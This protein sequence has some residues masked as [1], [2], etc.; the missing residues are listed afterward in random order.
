LTAVKFS[1]KVFKNGETEIDV[2]EDEKVEIEA[3][4]RIEVAK[5]DKQ[6]DQS[7][8]ILNFP[9]FLEVELFTNAIV[10]L[11]DVR[12]ESGGS[13]HVT[14]SL[15]QGHMFVGLTDDTNSRVTV[16][17]PD[18]VINTL[19][20][21]TEFNI[22]KAKDSLTCAQVEKGS[23]EITAE[24][25][26]EI[27]RAG[28]ASFIFKDEPPSSIICAP[29]EIFKAWK[30]QYRLKAGTRTLGAMVAGL[31]ELCAWQTLELPPDARELY[32]D[33]FTLASSGWKQEK[34]DNYFIGYTTPE[35]YHIQVR[36]PGDKTIVTLPFAR[37]FDDVNIDL[38]AVTGNAKDGDFRYGV[39]F[40]QSG[41]QYYAF[42]I[43]PTTQTWYVLKVTSAGEEIL[44]ESTNKNIQ[45][46]DVEDT[47][48]VI[49]K[50]SL[51]TFYINGRLV[52]QLLNAEDVRGDIGLFVETLDSSSALIH[53][54]S[55]TLWDMPGPLPNSTPLSKENC[56]NNRDDDGDHFVDRDDPDCNQ[57][58]VRPTLTP[59]I[60]IVPGPGGATVTACSP[61]EEDPQ[62]PDSNPYD[63]RIC[64]CGD[65]VPGGCTDPAA[66]NYDPDAPY[67]DG[68][69]EYQVVVYGCTDPAAT[70]YNPNATDDDG[71]CTYAPPPVSGCTDPAA[72]NY[73]PNATV[74]DGS[75]TYPPP[76]VSGCTDPAATNYDPNATV[77]DGSC[78]Y[79]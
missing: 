25:K 18:A 37:K 36:Q 10:Q 71:S 6:E 31:R 5:I 48:R 39:V 19:E 3:D 46:L 62:C 42:A 66:T 68:S 51:A 52:Y 27:V 4:D 30:E 8:S 61:P 73:D 56:F 50:D 15:S 2:E 44:S 16:Q 75:C 23:V 12:K 78:T 40:R 54:D 29:N 26:T 41:D 55:V 1:A 24:G 34:N 64:D 14:L 69:C 72:T 33:E 57:P 74:D 32:N 63:P 28:E 47:L 76:P 22:C 7:Y 20:D 11:A 53:F 35:Y 45:G 59:F 49:A 43:A 60:P 70:N 9:D 58:D 67:D 65:F 13:T 17:T 38:R 77:D 79:G 21:G